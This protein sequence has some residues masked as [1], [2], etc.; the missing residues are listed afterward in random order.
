MKTF[1]H[2]AT[3]STG[4]LMLI[5]NEPISSDHGPLYIMRLSL[6]HRT[7]GQNRLKSR[8]IARQVRLAAQYGYIGHCTPDAAYLPIIVVI[9]PNIE[10]LGLFDVYVSTSMPSTVDYWQSHSMVLAFRLGFPAQATK[11]S[12]ANETLLLIF[13]QHQQRSCQIN[14]ELREVPIK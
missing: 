5:K 1:T 2:C 6:K 4:L 8:S 14:I 10:L 13:L 3:D 7:N 12:H 11:G 9:R